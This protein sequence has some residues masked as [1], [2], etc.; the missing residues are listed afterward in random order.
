[1]QEYYSQR[2]STPGTFLITEAT[3]ITSKAGGYR[4]IPGIWNQEQLRAWRSIVEGVHAAKSYIYCQLWA[5][6]RTA[7]EKMLKEDDPSFSVVG[8]S[9]IAVKE[10]APIPRELTIP[11]IQEYIQSYATAARNAVHEAQFDG[12]EIHSANGYLIDQ[13]LQ[14]VSNQRQDEYGGSVE[15]RSRF[16]LEVVR[17]VVGAVGTAKKVGIRLSPWSPF[18]GMSMQDPVPQ[19]SHFVTA[20]KQEFPGLAYIHVVEARIAGGETIDVQGR[21]FYTANDFLR[22]IWR[23]T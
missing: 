13:F 9:P 1:M 16:G 20:L 3:F 18:N 23:L 14:D 12:V 17:A 5:L 2:G 11:E 8:P 10:G 22:A 6:G 15:R 7:D 4:H 19:F 21:D